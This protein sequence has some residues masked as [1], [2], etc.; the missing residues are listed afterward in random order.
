MRPF[1]ECGFLIKGECR[2][3]ELGT[4]TDQCGNILIYKEYPVIRFCPTVFIY[5]KSNNCFRTFH[6]AFVFCSLAPKVCL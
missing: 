2:I 4:E 3:D 6:S 5:M 1:S